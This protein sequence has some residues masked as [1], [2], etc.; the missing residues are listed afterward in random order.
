MTPFMRRA[1]AFAG[2]NVV[3][4]RQLVSPITL[5]ANWPY[6]SAPFGNTDRITTSDGTSW[7]SASF[8]GADFV[9]AT[10]LFT[11]DFGSAKYIESVTLYGIGAQDDAQSGT[12]PSMR[13]LLA[14]DTGTFRDSGAR[15]GAGNSEGPFALGRATRHLYLYGMGAT[16]FGDNP[17]GHYNLDLFCDRFSI[18]G[19]V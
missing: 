8:G 10:L 6:P 18:R 19:E 13:Y 16:G 7:Y 2:P 11:W 3:D 9:T 5:T 15:S 4:D 17:N 14:D 1:Q 12:I